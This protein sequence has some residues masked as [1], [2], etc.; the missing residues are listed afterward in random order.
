MRLVA[1]DLPTDRPTTT[2]AKVE[3]N[4]QISIFLFTVR[5]VFLPVEPCLPP[6]SMAVRNALMWI[7]LD[8]IVVV[9]S[10]TNRRTPVTQ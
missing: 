5:F 6:A 1:I 2:R 9:S 10:S 3:V 7:V 4:K 8:G